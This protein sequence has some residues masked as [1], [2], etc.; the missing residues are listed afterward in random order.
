MYHQLLI[1]LFK[2]TLQWNYSKPEGTSDK[3]WRRQQVTNYLK[4]CPGCKPKDVCSWV[5]S[6]SPNP[7]P[8]C[9][10]NNIGKI[11]RRILKP[12]LNEGISVCLATLNDNFEPL[13]FSWDMKKP[14]HV[15]IHHW[16][17]IQLSRY[18]NEF[19][20]DKLKKILD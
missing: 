2:M 7:W 4:A 17:M 5:S 8:L 14:R 10:A 11:I 1:K 16:R 15:D 9:N 18:I 12:C 3:T 19:P 6:H 13:S 20:N